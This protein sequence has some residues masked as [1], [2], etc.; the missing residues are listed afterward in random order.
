M[1]EYLAKK[2]AKYD[3]IGPPDGWSF[4]IVLMQNGL[5]VPIS[6]MSTSYFGTTALSPAVVGSTLETQC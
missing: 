6:E 4:K 3:P 2:K 5:S 1:K